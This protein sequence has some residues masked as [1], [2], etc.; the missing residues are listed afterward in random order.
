[1]T[2][3]PSHA[4]GIDLGTSNSAL[5]VAFPGEARSSRPVEITQVLGPGRIGEKRTFA[6]ALYLP[7]T[8]QFPP[9]SLRPPWADREPAFVAGDFARETGAQA[10]DRLVTSA[11]SWLSYRSVD[12]T[13]PIL[14]WGSDLKERK[15][16]PLEASR[17]YLEHLKEACRADAARNGLP[18]T[19]EDARFVLTVPASFD[20]VARKLTAQAARDAGLGNDVVLLEEPQAAFYAWLDS[21]G[22]AWREQVKPGD[23][24]LVCDV[25]GGT[26][27]FSLIAVAERSG[28][29]ELERISVGR[30]IL[31]GGDNMD[32]ALAYNLRGRLEEEGKELDEWQFMALVQAC[33]LAKEALF[34]KRDLAETPISI[35]S[36]GSSLFAG[37]LSTALPRSLLE[38]VIVEGFFAFTRPE[39]R[40]QERPSAGLRE[41]GLPYEADAVLSKHLAAFLAR[42]LRNVKASPALTALVS[43]NGRA[44]RL[45]A[46]LLRPDAV[47]FNG[48]VFRPK[49]LRDRVLELVA[50]WD[51]TRPVRELTG[52]DP[53]LAVARGAAAYGLTKIT[54]KGPRIRAGASRSYYIG[55]DPAVPAIPGYQPPVK[56]L[57]VV[58]QG[59]EEGSEQV[60]EDREF[61]LWTGTRVTFR[62][63]SSPSRAGDSVGT[64]IQN[65]ERDLEETSGLE[66]D[67]PAIEGLG[68][69]TIVPVKLHARLSELGTLELWM[70]RKD[71]PDRWELNFDV[72]TG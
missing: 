51:K 40:P 70:Q 3:G 22:P 23:L 64:V 56:A 31:L 60:L 47:L 5:A 35:P 63:F 21:V 57:C 15:I 61:G 13:Q 62:F 16:S 45:S 71:A 69:S 41:L 1:M 72:R 17:L 49:R 48:G 67:V 20:E 24:V 66:M 4:V 28:N 58:P 42:S 55:L 37:T 46:D 43:G 6:S 32:L 19:L 27:D 11:K 68:D 2:T 33:R 30:H 29:L 52:S 36:R 44:D 7:V 34:D 12:P 10:P 26:T 9:D 59:M 53:D 25:G 54:G 65:A 8:G 18:A 38:S 39:V 50:S 14:P